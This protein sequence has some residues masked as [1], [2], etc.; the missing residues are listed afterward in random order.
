[1]TLRILRMLSLE[2]HLGRDSRANL[3]LR[4]A[5]I[6]RE[7]VMIDKEIVARTWVRN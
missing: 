1:M 4:S 7:S 3:K 6:S 2:D 5:A